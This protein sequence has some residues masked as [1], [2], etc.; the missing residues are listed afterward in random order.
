DAIDEMELVRGASE[1][2]AAAGNHERAS[3]AREVRARHRRRIDI[4]ANEPEYAPGDDDRFDAVTGQVGDG[5]HL[6]AEGIGEGDKQLDYDRA[7]VGLQHRT[8][9]SVGCGVIEGIFG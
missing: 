4:F 2:R 8:V 5:F 6:D 9:D 1:R 7:P 3:V